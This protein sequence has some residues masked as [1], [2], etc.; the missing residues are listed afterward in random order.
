MEG[1]GIYM[2][3]LRVNSQTTAFEYHQNVSLL[4]FGMYWGEFQTRLS[5]EHHL[6]IYWKSLEFIRMNS[7]I[8]KCQTSS[9][10]FNLEM[11]I[12]ITLEEC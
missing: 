2:S 5:Y 4:V 1:F 8:A 12:E 10:H 3:L 11:E 7:G 9:K 6:N